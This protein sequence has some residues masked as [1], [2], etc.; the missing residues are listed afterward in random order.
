MVLGDLIPW[1]MTAVRVKGYCSLLSHSYSLLAK[2]PDSFRT[3]EMPVAFREQLQKI[4]C[5]TG[6]VIL[7]TLQAARY[8]VLIQ[9]YTDP[10]RSTVNS[11]CAIK[12]D[13]FNIR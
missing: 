9:W 11:A 6:A 2:L 4:L 13:Q 7:P 3:P 1:A 8:I 5:I 12:S 10:T